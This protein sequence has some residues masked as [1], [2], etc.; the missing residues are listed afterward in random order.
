MLTK[1]EKIISYFVFIYEKQMIV[2]LKCK[3]CNTI[4]KSI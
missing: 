4:I 1:F 2:L 3:C